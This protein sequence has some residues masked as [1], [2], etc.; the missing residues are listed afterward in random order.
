M[1]EENIVCLAAIRRRMQERYHFENR[2]QAFENLWFGWV[3]QSVRRNGTSTQN[4]RQR[5]LRGYI[6][7][8]EADDFWNYIIQ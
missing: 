8:D 6:K 3:H 7:K 1:R 5:W 2:N 4:Y